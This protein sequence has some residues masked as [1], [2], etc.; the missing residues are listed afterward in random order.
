MEVYLYDGKL[1]VRE[2]FYEKG[3]TN[4]DICLKLDEVG[5]TRQQEI[6]ADGAEPK[7]IE[8]IYRDGWLIEGVKKPDNSINFGIDM[9]KRYE[10]V[11]D[12]A[13]ENLKKEF[14]M[15]K[16]KVDKNGEPA[17]VPIKTHDHA[18]D[19]LRYVVFSALFDE[20]DGVYAIS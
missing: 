3:L 18:M 15:Y 5:V 9:V 7:S 13:S 14:R 1:Y 6:I 2:L 4:M 16:W 20:Y 10:I 8:E 17:N 11:C 12:P 19:A